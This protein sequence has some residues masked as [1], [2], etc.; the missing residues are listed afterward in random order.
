MGAWFA[1]SNAGGWLDWFVTVRRGA[2]GSHVA[3]FAA[4]LLSTYGTVQ[5]ICL[6]KIFEGARHRWER[7]W[8]RMPALGVPIDSVFAPENGPRSVAMSKFLHCPMCVGWW[9]GAF[10]HVVGFSCF[11]PGALAM[12]LDGAAASAWCWGAFVAHRLAV[13]KLEKMGV[14]L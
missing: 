1:A 12:V 5:I 6:S 10:L 11:A 4:W 13:T 14:I 8:L 7:W 2:N 3:L 9:M